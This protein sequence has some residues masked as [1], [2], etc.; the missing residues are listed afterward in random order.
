MPGSGNRLRFAPMHSRCAPPSPAPPESRRCRLRLLSG[1]APLPLR[2]VCAALHLLPGISSVSSLSSAAV[3]LSV[4]RCSSVSPSSRRVVTAPR[5]RRPGF[6]AAAK[7]VLLLLHLVLL[8]SLSLVG[9][10]RGGDAVSRLR[11]SCSFRGWISDF[12]EYSGCCCY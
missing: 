12:R 1:A 2:P 7:Y 10:K 8:P 6:C 4:Q 11:R 5:Q 3:C 9:R